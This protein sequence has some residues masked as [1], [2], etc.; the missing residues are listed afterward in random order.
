VWDILGGHCESAET[1]ADTLGREI[2][3][4]LGVTASAY[5]EVAVLD[6]PRPAEHGEAR[7]HVFVVTAWTGGEPRLTGAEHSE[8]RWV[9]LDEALA[10]PLA[11]PDY[12]ALFRSVLGESVSAGA[13]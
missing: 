4:E 9:S 10:L 12:G 3:E 8:L 5:E 11:H 1:P 6:E 13:S 2:Q 7:Y